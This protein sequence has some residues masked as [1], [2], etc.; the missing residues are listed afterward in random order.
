MAKSE[1][2]VVSLKEA[3]YTGVILDMLF[4]AFSA[5]IMDEGVLLMITACLTIAHWTLNA[6]ILFS[7]KTRNSRVGKDFIR[8][9]LLPLIFVAFVF[10]SLLGL[11]GI[12]F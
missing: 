1:K 3:I 4:L 5:T 6:A 2:A 7:K 10:R 9:G 8:F 11:L 12:G